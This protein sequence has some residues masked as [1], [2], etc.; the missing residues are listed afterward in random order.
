VREL[1]VALIGGGGVMGQ[2]HS[3]GWALAPAMAEIGA[4]VTKAVVADVSDDVAATAAARYGWAE[5]TSDWRSLLTRDD[6]D[7]IDIVT[8]PNL[9]Q[10]IAL[11][12]LAAGKHVFVEKPVTNDA[13]EAAE[14]AEAAR[15]AGVVNQVGFNYRH[16]PA[17]GL[18]KRLIED[19]ALGVPLQYRTTY[20]MDPLF[21]VTDFGW[22]AKKSTGGSGVVGDIGSHIL[23][24]AEYLNGD[25]VAVTGRLRARPD[26]RGW[27]DDAERVAQ[28]LTDDAGVW[29]AE[30]A[31]GAI[32]TFAVNG[33]SSGH[34]NH[35]GFELDGTRGAIRFDWNM[36]D[37]LQISSAD[38]PV[39]V[40]GFRTVMSSGEHADVWTPVPGLGLGYTDSTAV[41]LQKFVR[42]IVGGGQASPSFADGARTQQIVEAVWESA[43]S[44]QWVAVAPRGAAVR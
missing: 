22:R 21:V 29:L 40:S 32:G 36:R 38:D 5:S 14:L 15:Q 6:I 4:S 42:A 37:A 7:V 20:L 12:A 23:D 2:A 30:F 31:N 16:I 39:E 8:P 41:Q 18:A 17:I 11:A 43:E 27:I 35:L 26:E 44:G 25:I 33:W 3:L 19:G 9:H 10:P 1:R 28:D 13:A 24:I 34:K